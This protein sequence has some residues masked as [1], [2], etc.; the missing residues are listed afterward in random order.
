[1][2]TDITE[3]K[4]AEE[5]LRESEELHRAVLESLNDAIV[6]RHGEYNSGGKRVYANSAFRRMHGIGDDADISVVEVQD[7]VLP[8]D[9]E[10]VVKH[11][12]ARMRGD[13]GSA[14]RIPS[15]AA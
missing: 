4:K 5:A 6:V 11:R 8:E 12:E 15:P 14:G 3:R 7:W 1:M 10:L 13:L 9:R 2:N